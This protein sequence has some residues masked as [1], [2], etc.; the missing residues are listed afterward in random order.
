MMLQKMASVLEVSVRDMKLAGQYVQIVFHH[1]FTIVTSI[2][3][4]GGGSAWTQPFW[5]WIEQPSGERGDTAPS[6]LLGA[7]N[8]DVI[9][10]GPF[11][12]I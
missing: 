5:S 4:S 3:R 10:K 12:F 2:S 11:L 6:L 7:V 1:Y 8:R 9:L